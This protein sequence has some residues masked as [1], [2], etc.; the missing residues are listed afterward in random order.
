MNFKEDFFLGH[1][2]GGDGDWRRLRREI[3]GERNIGLV[4]EKDDRDEKGGNMLER[5]NATNAAQLNNQRGKAPKKLFFLIKSP[6]S[7][8]PPYI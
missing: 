7:V 5:A 6:K 2:V 8:T 4:K 3:A 1:P